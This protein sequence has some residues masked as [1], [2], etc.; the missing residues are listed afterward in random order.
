[1]KQK[2]YQGNKVSRDVVEKEEMK[3]YHIL[4]A[5]TIWI[6]YKKQ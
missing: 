1:M 5:F 2:M 3:K 6:Y 4:S